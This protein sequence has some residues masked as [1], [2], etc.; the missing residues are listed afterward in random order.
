MSSSPHHAC[1]K[2]CTVNEHMG[3]GPGDLYDPSPNHQKNIFF[4][5]ILDR[6]YDIDDNT[7][8]WKEIEKKTWNEYFY[9]NHSISPNC[10]EVLKT[11]FLLY[12]VWG[13][14]TRLSG[15]AHV[16]ASL[17]DFSTNPL[18]IQT[19]DLFSPEFRPS[20]DSF[21]SR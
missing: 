18:T 1:V 21:L 20:A 13:S 11:Q 4:R 16:W 8:F 2:Y 9:N 17:R 19:E 12:Y 10:F 6:L 3:V 7:F 5:S 15:F 14:A